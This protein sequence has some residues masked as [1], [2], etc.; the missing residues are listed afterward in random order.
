MKLN[1]RN[2][3]NAKAIAEYW[4]K[5][6]DRPDWY[7]IEA[8]AEGNTEIMIYDVL[9]WPY[10]DVTALVRSLADIKTGTITVRINSPGGDVFDCV[11]LYNALKNHP[12][13]VTTRIES[14]A[15]SSASFLALAGK[16]TQAY[17][18]SMLMIHNSWVLAAGNKQ[19]LMDIA[20]VLGK[21]DGNMRDI[22][23]EKTKM[24]KREMA[25]MMDDETYMTAQEAKD[26]GFVDTILTSGK[27][28]KAQF[29]LPF[30][31]VPDCLRVESGREPTERDIERALRD[32]GLSKNKAKKALALLAG[33]SQESG[34]AELIAAA[35]K[36]LSICGG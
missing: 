26:K 22:Y 1:Y 21:I 18:N 6:L 19:D 27:A 5:P 31:N 7:K 14:L 20:D 2:S 30:A 29:D 24:G 10:N 3:R 15:A 35:Q 28:A 33:C 23:T 32:V 16:E 25:Q 4:N 9:G 13:A 11:A 34:E 36:T 8:L 12:C 17:S